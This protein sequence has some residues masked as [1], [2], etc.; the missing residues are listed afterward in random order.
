MHGLEIELGRFFDNGRVI[1]SAF[2]PAGYR[3]SPLSRF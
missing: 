3:R 2:S 1:V